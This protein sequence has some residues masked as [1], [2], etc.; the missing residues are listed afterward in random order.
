MRLIQEL[1]GKPQRKTQL[2]GPRST[3]DDN[4][5]MDLREIGYELQ[6]TAQDCNQW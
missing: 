4:I 3:W 2:Q 6:C 1:H 5:K